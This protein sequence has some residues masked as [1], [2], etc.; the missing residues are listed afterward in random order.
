MAEMLCY[1]YIFHI[2]SLMLS[3]Y[4]VKHKSTKILQFH[5]KTVKN[6]VRTLPYFHQFNNFWQIHDKIAET[7]CVVLKVCPTPR[8]QA[9]R[10]R[11]HWPIASSTIDWSKRPHSSITRISSSLTSVNYSGAVNFL[12][13][14]VYTPCRCY[15]LLGS[16]RVNSATT[17]L[18][19]RSQ[20]PFA[21]GKRRCR[22]LDAQVH[23]PVE[24]QNPTLGFSVYVWQ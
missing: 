5:R 11:R 7:L 17:V 15:S 6:Y 3:H 23:R 4:L 24:R 13:H 18:E 19:K 22:V 8:T 1:I 16:D 20:A 12:L 10:R 21:P 14:K 2:T 9:L